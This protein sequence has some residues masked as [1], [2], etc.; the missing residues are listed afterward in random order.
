ML[1]PFAAA[2]PDLVA[3]RPHRRARPHG[4][5]R[6]APGGARVDV[7][8]HAAG[9]VDLLHHAG[10]TVPA[11]RRA[12]CVVTLHDLQPLRGRRRRG[13]HRSRTKRA[14]LRPHV[15][16]AVRGPAGSSC[17]ATSC[18]AP[19]SP[20]GADPDRVVV[21]PHAVARAPRPDAAP[22]LV[23]R[24]DLDGPVVLYAAITY[25]HKDHATLVEAFDRVR[26]QHPDA[27]ARAH[28]A[29]PAAP[30]RALR[31]A[32]RRPGLADRV[33]RLGRVPDADVAGLLRPGRG[34]GGALALRGLR[35]PRHRG[36]GR[37]R[38]GGGGRRHRPPRGAR[39]RRRARGSRRRR[40]PG[41]PRCP[42][43][44]P[45]PTAGRRPRCPGPGPGRRSFTRAANAAAFVEV[46][47]SAQRALSRR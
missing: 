17:P 43:S 7:A 37:R 27:R 36:D 40:G 22:H 12:P 20:A 47:R 28:R 1:A 26:P 24:Y 39:R 45:T 16:A 11:R 29:A 2:Y 6:A 18:A 41:R 25:P 23:A 46:Y 38:A 14:Y 19:C 44:W 10:G 32:W 8:G 21:V 35:A 34:R 30:R 31:P 9:G 13:P 5:S 4:R 3:D 42:T 15:P 33:R